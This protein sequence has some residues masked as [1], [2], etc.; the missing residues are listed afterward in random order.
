MFGRDLLRPLSPGIACFLSVCLACSDAIEPGGSGAVDLGGADRGDL[1]DL[2]DAD[3]APL[4]DGGDAGAVVDAGSTDA[5]TILALTAVTPSFGLA[6]GGG[7]VIVEG[8]GFGADIE[9]RF[10]DQ[11]LQNPSRIP[12][13]DAVTGNLPPLPPGVT[14]IELRSEGRQLRAE[15]AFVAGRWSPAAGLTAGPAHD[16]VVD[17]NGD[18][19]W[20]T[21]DY[22]LWLRPPGAP[23]WLDRSSTL[24]DFRV[25]DFAFAASAPQRR[26]LTGALDVLRSDDGRD[27]TRVSFT[28]ENAG[29]R[30]LQVTAD[31]P[32]IQYA[33]ETSVQALS[34]GELPVAYTD[35]GWRF[36][37][38]CMATGVDVRPIRPATEA[39][40]APADQHL[41]LWIG[42]RL[43]RARDPL[44]LSFEPM[45]AGLVGGTRGVSLVAARGERLFALVPD[46]VYTAERPGGLW[47]ARGRPDPGLG[48][49]LAGS[50]DLVYGWAAGSGAFSMSMD[51][52]RSWSFPEGAP[53]GIEALFVPDADAAGH[54]FA[55]VGDGLF[56]SEDRGLSWAPL[57]PAPPLLSVTALVRDPTRSSDAWAGT[58]VGLHRSS[59]GGA[60]WR[61]VALIGALSEVLVTS[62]AVFVGRVDGRVEVSDD[63]G[64]S[65]AATERIPGLV[66][67]FEGPEGVHALG[68]RHVFR[69]HLTDW[70]RT[71]T[72]PVG[73]RGVAAAFASRQELLVATDAGGVLRSVDG[74]MTWRSEANGTE[75]LRM[76]ALAA[77]PGDA[78]LLYASAL[79]GST[80]AP[81]FLASG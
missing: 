7:P 64:Q 25:G 59:D 10:G 69:R 23:V 8:L 70:V 67:L 45:D 18:G 63:A 19:L 58:G 75:G 38:R 61:A 31:N 1:Q 15:A 43:Y 66:Q 73:L 32:D 33:L 44:C 60:T 54:V 65:F 28:P 21:S 41:V 81:R 51:G 68:E 14:S 26:Y 50:E 4:P 74:G 5:G 20:L 27:W 13:I 12:G 40:L 37:R 24:A 6:A 79:D 9:V 78:R 34:P 48:G 47:E 53:N 17:P 77:A 22:G 52:G 49:I 36:R 56:E 42:P 39:F 57:D 80:F 11:P 71:A 16:L 30:R 46:G 29:L 72:V 62:S 76:T 55:R 3:A 2:E 35:T